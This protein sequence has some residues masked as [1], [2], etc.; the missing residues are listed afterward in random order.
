MNVTVRDFLKDYGPVLL[1]VQLSQRLDRKVQK[2]FRQKQYSPEWFQRRT[3]WGR[4]NKQELIKSLIEG[5]AANPIHLL[6]REKALKYADQCGDQE[7]LN[8][9][10]QDSHEWWNLDGQQRSNAVVEFMENKFKLTGKYTDLNQK[11]YDFGKTGKN[12][13]E[14][15]EREQDNFLELKLSLN[16]MNNLTKEKCHEVFLRLNMGMDL[17]DME[18]LNA[19]CTPTAHQIREL[20][21]AHEPV[22]KKLCN[23]KWVR[24]EDRRWLTRLAVIL[25]K[26]GAADNGMGELKKLY[27]SKVSSEVYDTLDSTHDW[28]AASLRNNQKNLYARTYLLGSIYVAGK[29]S[30]GKQVK[31]GVERQLR[32]EIEKGIDTLYHNSKRQFGADFA[33]FQSG[34]GSTVEPVEKDYFF[35]WCKHTN[36]EKGLRNIMTALEK[37]LNP[38]TAGYFI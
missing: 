13:S 28:W 31:S 36:T 11:E 9:Y 26:G 22:M 33:T 20:A 10:N 37:Y 29:L 14:L 15:T 24:S 35:D 4:T 25:E 32:I 3:V 18:K 6:D 27:E 23:G 30:S 5:I 17:N 2:G 16:V 38:A 1:S 19:L 8:Y 12:F 34:Q 7:S 21:K